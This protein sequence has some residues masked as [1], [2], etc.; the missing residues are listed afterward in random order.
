MKFPNKQ[1]LALLLATA[2]LAALPAGGLLAA[3]GAAA[4]G[5]EAVETACLLDKA[6][7]NGAA[8]ADRQVKDFVDPRAY[9]IA[10]EKDRVRQARDHVAR[11]DR[12]RIEAGMKRHEMSL[13]LLQ[14]TVHWEKKEVRWTIVEPAQCKVGETNIPEWHGLWTVRMVRHDILIP[15]V[16]PK[17]V[18]ITIPVPHVKAWWGRTDGV[19]SIPELRQ[20]DFKDELDDAEKQ[21]GHLYDELQAG[22]ERIRQEQVARTEAEIRRLITERVAAALATIDQTEAA[23]LDPVEQQRAELATSADLA[24]RA[25]VAAG[26]N[27]AEIDRMFA[28]A[29][30]ALDGAVSAA[31]SEFA[32]RR[33]DT[34]QE[35]GQLEARY[36][37]DRTA[38][39]RTCSATQG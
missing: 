36:L 2:W 21:I 10:S 7:E 31:R 30:A 22:P 6:I 20:L 29:I 24:R 18:V 26:G 12:F 38:Q 37:A 14:T 25:A 16:K 5:D 11:H 13:H 33:D 28:P 1:L 15:C 17:D 9:R 27:P 35:F 19:V 23:T 8:T 34:R 4:E 3:E 39:A 32:E